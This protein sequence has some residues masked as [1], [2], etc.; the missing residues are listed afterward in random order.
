MR[1]NISKS[2]V[3]KTFHET[4]NLGLGV[5]PLVIYNIYRKIDVYAIQLDFF[6]TQEQCEMDALRLKV[7]TLETTLHKVRKGG[8]AGHN[9]NRRD[10]LELKEDVAL[11][12]RHICHGS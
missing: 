4:I 9:E 1:E 11:I 12:K 3:L 2:M 7:A 6:K 10:I 8:Y 5:F